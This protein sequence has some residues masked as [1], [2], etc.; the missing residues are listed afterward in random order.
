MHIFTYSPKCHQQ[1]PTSIWYIN[2]NYSP[3]T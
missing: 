1:I 2:H 3:R